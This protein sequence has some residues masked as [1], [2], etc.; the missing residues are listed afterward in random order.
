MEKCL[1]YFE[2]NKKDRPLLLVMST[3]PLINQALTQN[4]YK[5]GTDYMNADSLIEHN[6]IIGRTLI[7]IL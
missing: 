3:Y 2:Q 4:G 1:D 7:N 6:G 5:E